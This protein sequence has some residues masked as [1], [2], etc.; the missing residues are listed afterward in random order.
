MYT[1]GAGENGR[2]GLGD[3]LDKTS[4]GKGGREGGREGC[5]TAAAVFVEGQVCT[6]R[7]G[8]NGRLGSGD[9][10]DKTSP[11]KGGRKGGREGG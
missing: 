4:P 8:E 5:D 6:W 1:W 7:A 10:L 2:L 3:E 9:E 11:G